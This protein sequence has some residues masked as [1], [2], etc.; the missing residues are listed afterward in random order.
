LAM[1]LAEVVLE[2]VLET[3][4]GYVVCELVMR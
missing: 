3:M 4:M 2:M 1:V